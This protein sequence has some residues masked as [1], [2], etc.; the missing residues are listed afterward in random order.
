M[1]MLYA[2]FFINKNIHTTVGTMPVN[3]LEKNISY[4]ASEFPCVVRY[5]DINL[6]LCKSYLANDK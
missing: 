6:I 3:N 4:T 5:K 2:F 1:Q